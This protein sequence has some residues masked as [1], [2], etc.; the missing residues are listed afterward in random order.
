MVDRYL[1]HLYPDYKKFT[2]PVLVRQ[3]RDLL[4]CTFHGDLLRFEQEYLSPAADI[5]IRIKNQTSCHCC[6]MN[7]D[8]AKNNH[9]IS[10]NTKITVSTKK[11]RF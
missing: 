3:A 11:N 2:R 10:D 6:S 8:D 5:I 7:E 9:P 1:G 4:V